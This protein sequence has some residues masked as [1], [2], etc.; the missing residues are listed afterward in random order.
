ML[1][2]FLLVAIQKEFPETPDLK[3]ERKIGR[4]LTEMEDPRKDKKI[5]EQMI[6]KN[7]A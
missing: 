1:N 5:Q 3:I 2:Y 7:V 6:K 4:W